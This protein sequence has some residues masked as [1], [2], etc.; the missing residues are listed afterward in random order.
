VSIWVRRG[1]PNCQEG[2][3]MMRKLGPKLKVP[4]HVYGPETHITAI[5]PLALGLPLDESLK[6]ESTMLKEAYEELSH[7]LVGSP[8]SSHGALSPPH[9]AATPPIAPGASPSS[10]GA[11]AAAGAGSAGTGSASG[12][13]TDPGATRAWRLAHRTALLSL[14][15]RSTR[16]VGWGW[17]GV[18]GLRAVG[19]TRDE[20]LLSQ[21]APCTECRCPGSCV[22]YQQAGT[23]ASPLTPG[24]WSSGCRPGLCR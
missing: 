12:S 23:T 21:S 16:V 19:S 18:V 20:G 14:G 6:M 2:L 1:G 17:V 22:R 11:S 8:M 3:R 24:V 15:G 13:A 4:I 10:V 9:R 5:V 7:C